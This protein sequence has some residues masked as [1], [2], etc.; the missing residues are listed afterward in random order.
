MNQKN[1]SLGVKLLSAFEELPE[2]KFEKYLLKIS[3]NLAKIIRKFPEYSAWVQEKKRGHN[4]CENCGIQFEPG[5]IE[6]ELHHSPLTL[7]EVIYN[8]L[9]ERINKGE[10]EFTSLEILYDVLNAHFNDEI[11]YQIICDC[12]HTRI[13]KANKK[14]LQQ[15]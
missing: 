3:N 15:N 6:A 12:C 14:S 5:V 7:T 4:V 1:Y 11:D 8:F 13:H 10:W 9:K 2:E